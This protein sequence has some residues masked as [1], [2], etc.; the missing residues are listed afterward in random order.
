M[1]GRNLAGGSS[2]RRRRGRSA[3]CRCA[4]LSGQHHPGN[5]PLRSAVAAKVGVD[6]APRRAGTAFNVASNLGDRTWNTRC[7]QHHVRIDHEFNELRMSFSFWNHR[8]SIQS[9]GSGRV[10]LSSWRNHAREE[11]QL[12][13]QQVLPAHL[14]SSCASAVRLDRQAHAAEP[15]NRRLRPVVHGRQ[16]PFRRSG[17]ADVAVWGEPGRDPPE[18]RGPTRT[19]FRGQHP[20][21]QPRPVRLAA[22]RLPGGEP[23]AVLRRPHVGQ[24]PS[25]VED[26]LRVPPSSV[27]VHRLGGRRRRRPVR[28]QPPEHRRLRRQRQQPQ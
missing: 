14:H 9:C 8:P 25:H 6:G 12:L 16:L 13:R 18:R 7:A 11:H 17:L 26:R 21:Q 22:I 10:R 2:I 4:I 3:E 15:H 1:L 27:P 23:L 5:D 28:V 20:V 19:R 24:G